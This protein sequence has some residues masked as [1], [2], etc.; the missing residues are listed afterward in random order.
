MV[1][2]S[3]VT[4]I[5]LGQSH[6]CLGND[7]KNTELLPYHALS[8]CQKLYEE[9]LLEEK[10]ASKRLKSRS[11]RK[12]KS[13]RVLSHANQVGSDASPKTS[14]QKRKR[15]SAKSRA[16]NESPSIGVLGERGKLSSSSSCDRLSS[17]DFNSPGSPETE[18]SCS[19]PSKLTESLHDFA[20]K[21]PKKTLMESLMEE[22]ASMN[23]RNRRMCVN[24]AKPLPVHQLHRGSVNSLIAAHSQSYPS[25]P[26][27]PCLADGKEAIYVP[28]N[29]HSTRKQISVT[30]LRPTD[31]DVTHIRPAKH[32]VMETQAPTRLRPH[33][34]SHNA[35]Y[36]QQTAVRQPVTFTVS[37]EDVE[38]IDLIS[39]DQ[40]TDN[41]APQ[42][43][44]AGDE[45]AAA[46]FH[47]EQ[48]IRSQYGRPSQVRP[49]RILKNGLKNC[50]PDYLHPVPVEKQWGA[51][52]F[53]TA[54]TAKYWSHQHAH[55][56]GYDKVF[57]DSESSQPR[58][59]DRRAMNASLGVYGGALRTP[60]DRSVNHQY[61][62]PDRPVDAASSRLHRQAYHGDFCLDS[63]GKVLNFFIEPTFR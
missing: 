25:S 36:R 34:L 6:E 4:H 11:L 2:Y 59:R 55:E 47:L 19:A 12:S 58:K 15:T 14:D 32:P 33:F 57:F 56:Q 29:V 23:P 35:Q 24:S 30:S 48:D 10:L 37:S 1:R 61:G 3:P 20:N 45:S 43:F 42:G 18:S 17:A 50:I 62:F 60:T 26:S 46:V 27:S 28:P 40:D 44:A 52:D 22:T 7:A 41:E 53:I 16:I 63:T 8:L 54:S 38:T 31:G 5:L 9:A 39:D 21:Y 13:L 49:K 51:P